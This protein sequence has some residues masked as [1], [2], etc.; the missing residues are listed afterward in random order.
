MSAIDPLFLSMLEW[1]TGYPDS[2]EDYNC[3][4]LKNKN[5]LNVPCDNS[6]YF[7]DGNNMSKPGLGYL[8]ET[9]VITSKVTKELCHFPFTYQQ[10]TFDSC[11]TKPV[12]NFNP[13]GEPWCATKVSPDGNVMN[14][15][16]ALCQDER[17]IIYDGSGDGYFCPMPFIYDRV[18]FD[19]CTRKS[20]DG[21]SRYEKQ[22]WCPDPRVVTA[23]NVFNQGDDLGNCTE[24]LHPPG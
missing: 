11:S 13:E 9:R 12:A 19:Y 1:E 8:C 15:Q 24:F 20:H 10:V 21:A 3:V 16:W 2:T 23:N 6:T 7:T 22:F 4:A 17:T 14:Y 18:Y 5:I